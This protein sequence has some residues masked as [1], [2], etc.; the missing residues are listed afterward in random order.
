M[1][2]YVLIL[3]QSHTLTCEVQIPFE[4]NFSP[5]V[6]WYMHYGGNMENTTPLPMEMQ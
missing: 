1:M 4:I 6:Q 3:G 2:V 5:K